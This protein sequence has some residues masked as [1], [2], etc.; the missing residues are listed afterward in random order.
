MNKNGTGIWQRTTKDAI[1]A[2]PQERWEV[3]GKARLTNATAIAPR[4]VEAIR[5]LRF[6]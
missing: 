1:S 2:S 6:W 3:R 5:G 4:T